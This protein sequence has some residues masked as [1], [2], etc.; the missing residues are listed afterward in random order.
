MPLPR[1][2][3]HISQYDIPYVVYTDDMSRYLFTGSVPLQVVV[4]DAL[5][6]GPLGECI[7]S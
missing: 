6:D 4:E 3:L 5:P 1:E 2:F 7:V